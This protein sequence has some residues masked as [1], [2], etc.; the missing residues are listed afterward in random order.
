VA[1]RSRKPTRPGARA[2][3]AWRAADSTRSRR[4]AALAGTTTGSAKP[5]QP[6]APAHRR[7]ANATSLAGFAPGRRSAVEASAV[8]LPTKNGATPQ[9]APGTLALLVG[10]APRQK[11][12]VERAA[13]ARREPLSAP[14]HISGTGGEVP[15]PKSQDLARTRARGARRRLL[16][17]AG[18][19]AAS[20]SPA[21]AARPSRDRLHHDPA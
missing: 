20:S 7:T 11:E 8:V 19:T 16:L 14:G 18:R 21:T 6:A 15:I 4:R 1:C 13:R 10:V 17:L 12:G 3:V 2:A 9:D 5:S